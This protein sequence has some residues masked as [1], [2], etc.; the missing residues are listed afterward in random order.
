MQGIAYNI[1]GPTWVDLVKLLGKTQQDLAY[2]NSLM[3]V[4]YASTAAFGRQIQT[5]CLVIV[6]FFITD[7]AN[8]VIMSFEI[9][10]KNLALFM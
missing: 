9:Q 1:W 2:G 4:G 10:T 8:C 7:Y 6:K 3:A 5:L